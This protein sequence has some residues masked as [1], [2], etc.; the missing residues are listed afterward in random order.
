MKHIEL[1]KGFRAKVDDEDFDWINKS[2]W[3]FSSSGSGAYY[4]KTSLNDGNGGTKR[5]YM[6]RRIMGATAGIEIDHI[7]GNGLNNQKANLR[8]CSH[9]QNMHN[10]KPKKTRTSRYKG[11]SRSMFG[12]KW[13]VIIK[14]N[15][16]SH[17]L[18]MYTHEKAAARE[19]DKLARLLHGEFA[20]VNFPKEGERGVL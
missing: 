11:V 9:F 19:Y 5:V 2:K 10:I 1:T 7:D 18:G 8:L 14:H 12:N 13:C 4:A 20:C 3:H 6:H 16:V 17:N 15:G